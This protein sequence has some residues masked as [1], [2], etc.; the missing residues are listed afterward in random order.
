M[1]KD[2]MP[3]L[4]AEDNEAQRRYLS[5]LLTDKFPEHAPVIEASDGE[6]AVRMAI[7]NKASL[8]ILD[9]QMPVLDGYD[10][11]GEL[12]EDDR[13]RATPAIAMTAFAMRGDEAKVLAAGFTRYVSK[14]FNITDLRHVVAELLTT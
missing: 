9:I 12:R 6:A 1:T 8:S 7:D 3:I 13:F 14:P 11:I 2:L 10:V 5:E 4:I